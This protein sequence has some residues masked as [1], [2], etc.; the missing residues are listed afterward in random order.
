MILG[1]AV[2][3]IVFVLIA[4]FAIPDPG[5]RPIGIGAA[6]LA[7]ATTYLAIRT[8]YVAIVAPDGS[9]TFKALTRASTTNLSAVYRITNRAAGRGGST[10]SFYFD[11]GSAQMGG[12][13]GPDLARCIIAA[14]PAVE[15]PPRLVR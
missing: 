3:T 5:G 11:G 6:I 1:T 14:N 13:T 9:L 4:R 15:Y 10:W 8:P 2:F 7:L 12:I